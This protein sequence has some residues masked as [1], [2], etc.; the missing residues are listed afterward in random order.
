MKRS[1]RNTQQDDDDDGE[2]D[3]VFVRE[4]N[5]SQLNHKPTAP[6]VEEY[7]GVRDGTIPKVLGRTVRIN[8]STHKTSSTDA[9][10]L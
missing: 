7:P 10:T 4:T 6:T 5:L 1:S 9:K 2:D 3:V 8:R